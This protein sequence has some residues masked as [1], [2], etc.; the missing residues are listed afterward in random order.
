[1]LTGR[2]V[3]DQCKRMA[4]TEETA[5]RMAVAYIAQRGAICRGMNISPF[6]GKKELTTAAN[7]GII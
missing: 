1:M 5:L 6:T 3:L 7:R 4:P 2:E